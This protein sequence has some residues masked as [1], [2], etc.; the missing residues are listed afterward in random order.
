MADN[1]SLLA[2]FPDLTLAADAID[3]LRS[4]GLSDDHMNVISGIPVTEAMLGRPNQ[5][6]NVPRI[7]GGGAALGF[8]AAVLLTFVTPYMYPQPIQ[9]GTQATIPGP[10]TIVLLFELTML[11]MLLSTFLGVFLDSYFPNYRPM[12]YVKEVSD[13]KIAIFFTCPKESKDKFT[14]AMTALGA[15]KVEVAEVDHL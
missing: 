8:L 1:I 15:E 14:K 2:V 13:G 5:W 12:E 7:A 11:G 3:Q 10:P 4:L 9:V 6:T